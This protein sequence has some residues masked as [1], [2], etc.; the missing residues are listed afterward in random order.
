M[1]KFKYVY[2][3]IVVL[4]FGSCSNE[5]QLVK[6]SNQIEQASSLLES[7]QLTNQILLEKLNI[8]I[9][10]DENSLFNEL[11]KSKNFILKSSDVKI[12]TYETSDIKSITIPV[13]NG[14]TYVTFSKEDKISE[15]G[16]FI[17]I[18]QEDNKQLVRYYN[19]NE[20]IIGGFAVNQGIITHSFGNINETNKK[21]TLTNRGWWSTW[22]DCVG[23]SLT[24]MTD[25]SVEG[26]IWGLACIAFGPECA[27]GTALG[28]A[29]A[30]TF[31]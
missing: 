9:K 21:S 2:L 4:F 13:A 12:S 14:Y 31:S 18:T 5:E 19:L 30:A 24:K 6:E 11:N 16:M 29:A 27:A 26:S 1:R 10:K 17:K 7:K 28:C 20:E 15:I 3:V 8:K 25:G 23:S 22:G